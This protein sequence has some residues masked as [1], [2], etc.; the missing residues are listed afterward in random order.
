MKIFLITDIHYGEDVNYP[1]AGGVDYVNSYG[2]RVKDVFPALLP[3]MEGC[4]LVVN[5]GDFIVD[6]NSEKDIAN[7][8]SGLSMFP[9]N[10]PVKHVPGNHDVFNIQRE[11]WAHLV[12]EKNSYYS[13]D[14]NGYHH[15]VLDGNRTF[16]RGPLYLGEEQLFWLENDLA[17]TSLNTI[18]YCHHSIDNQSMDNNYYFKEKPENASLANKYFVRR[19]LEKSG[20]VIAVFSGHTHFYNQQIVNNITYCT[21]P[22][23]SENNGSNEPKLEYAIVVLDGNQINIVIKKVESL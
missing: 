22:S 14:V 11:E 23:F 9:T 7:Y 16:R 10:V 21:V 4:D 20:K 1:N 19:I 18:V 2:E 15:I 3:E 5:L 17:K 12:G 8:K 6:K 13:F